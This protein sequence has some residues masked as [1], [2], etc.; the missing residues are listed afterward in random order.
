[1]STPPSDPRYPPYPDRFGGRRPGAPA[2]PGIVPLRPLGIGELLTGGLAV[3]RRHY[4]VLAIV[5]LVFSALG[6]VTRLATVNVDFDAQLNRMLETGQVRLTAAVWVPLLVDL[7][8]SLLASVV[9]TAVATVYCAQDV[10]GRP[11]SVAE[12]RGRIRPVLLPLLGLAL[13]IAVAVSLGLLVLI[14]PGVLIFLIWLAAPSVLVLERASIPV[15]L[16]RSVRL[17]Q[18]ERGRLFGM[19]A[20]MVGILMAVGFVLGI[21][22]GGMGLDIASGGGWWV[23]QILSALL[24]TVTTTWLASVIAL[25]Y[26]DLRI[27]KE[28]L[29]PT[30]AA[31]AA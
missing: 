10:L 14:V 12:L 28:N 29:G 6:I 5:S 21:L 23:M 22:A 2:Q 26:V 11:T 15:A 8:I 25:A 13:I 9:I 17:T 3:V 31:A 24:A 4:P 16:N 19:L 20:A 30:L 1:M 18:G 7:L 27:R